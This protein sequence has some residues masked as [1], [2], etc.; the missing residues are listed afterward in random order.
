M[1]SW[2][3]V[4]LNCNGLRSSKEKRLTIFRYLKKQKPHVIFLQE[5]HS[6]PSD[7][8]LWEMEFGK[9]MYLNHC[10]GTQGA[11]TAI[12]C[13]LND[14]SI[15]S[16]QTLYDGRVQVVRVQINHRHVSLINV[17]AP[18]PEYERKHFF[19]KI[20]REVQAK[21]DTELIFGGDFN[22]IQNAALDR[23]GGNTPSK[24]G[25]EGLCKMKKDLDLVDIWRIKNP[26]K[27]DYTWRTKNRQVKSR[28]DYFLISDSLKNDVSK[29]SIIDSLKTDHKAIVIQFK[30]EPECRGPNFWKLN[31]SFL[32]DTRYCS[33][34]QNT[35]NTVWDQ[36]FDI[37]DLRIRWD[38]LKFE[39]QSASIIFTKAKAKERRQE[40]AKAW[41]VLNEIDS[42][43][44][45]GE[46]SDEDLNRY[47]VTKINLEKIE[48]YKAK[49]EYIRSR[50]EFIEK[51]EKSTS[52]FYSQAKLYSK[53]KTLRSL[54]D[55]DGNE[56]SDSDVVLSKIKQFYVD[57]YSSSNPKLKGMEWEQI[58]ATP[59]VGTL[60]DHEKEF[61]DRQI[62][63]D[64]CLI[65]LKQMKPN[66]SPG[67][68]GLGPEFYL[69]FWPI[70]NGKLLQV[71]KYSLE[72]GE[73]SQ[74]QRRAVITLLHKK[75]KDERYIKNWRPISLLNYDYKILTKVLAKRTDGV[76]TKLI[77]EDQSGFIKGRFIGENVRYLSDLIEFAEAEQY[78][79]ILLSLDFFKAYDTI[80]W[81][82]LCECLLKFNFGPAMIKWIKTCYTNIFSTVMNNGFSCGWF[83]I[84]RG[85]RQGCPLSG[86][87][88][89]LCIEIFGCM[90][91][92]NKNIK[93]VKINKVEKKMV[94]FADDTNC[95]VVDW[96]SVEQL[97]LTVKSFSKYSGLNVNIDK[98]ML[99]WMG[100]WRKKAIPRELNVK[101]MTHTIDALGITIGRN[102]DMSTKSNFSDKIDKMTKNFDRWKFR[103]LSLL[104]RI[105]ITKSFG[106]SNLVYSMSV[107]QTPTLIIKKAQAAINGFIWN[108][109]TTRVKHKTLIAPYDCGGL[110]APDVECQHKALRVV[111]VGRLL[112]IRSWGII[113]H[114]YFDKYGGLEFLLKCDYSTKFLHR[115]PIFYR[116]MLNYLDEIALKFD[117]RLII[118]N[119][120]NIIINGES[121][122]WAD[123]KENGVVYI[124]DLQSEDGIFL[125]YEAFRAKFT[126]ETNFVK[127]YSLLCAVRKSQLHNI[128]KVNDNKSIFLVKTFNNSIINLKKAKSRAFYDEY[129]LLC[130]KEP[131][132]VIKWIENVNTTEDEFYR[133][134]PA[135]KRTCGET[136]LL[137]FHYKT[138]HGYLAVGTNLYKWKL[139]ESDKCSHCSDRDT[140]T[141][142]LFSCPT[143]RAWLNEIYA[144]LEYHGIRTGNM[145]VRQFMFGTQSKPLNLILTIVKY[146]I[147]KVRHHN[148]KFNLNSIRYEIYKRLIADKNRL[149]EITFDIKWS[150]Y[151]EII[152]DLKGDFG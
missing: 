128:V 83:Q 151:S 28:L 78:P 40:E 137:D 36:S 86:I 1:Q 45:A 71:Y 9:K 108:N 66:K 123:W 16:H 121:V 37:S 50:A 141:H 34:I 29:V 79:C 7:E 15:H 111:W 146:Y 125:T 10:H 116:E 126:I 56:I 3:I 87:L 106:L 64:E 139:R 47:E 95:T 124:E 101:V 117:S 132:A 131:T 143:T 61:M 142:C 122:F 59:V 112:Q 58:K 110:R 22:T 48:S 88:F 65:A 84:L 134:Y 52:F 44:I 74:S 96:V 150:Q 46:A 68:D 57:L 81:K 33:L 41:E 102:A 136:K 24:V 5:T 26:N 118:W 43:I 140:I 138:L 17:Y 97:F 100:P 25:A 13:T 129:I 92:E 54:V 30:F 31:Q 105:L 39:I 113:A 99:L 93:G 2:K 115:I 32:D 76:L 73:L 60:T 130:S 133:S 80:E 55:E 49:G 8:S 67:C 149:T 94:Q 77:H 4:S 103:N 145:D 120:R 35:I 109:S 75:C 63:S 20:K 51:D 114:F 104:G 91:R 27:R 135:V 6:T 53:K 42:R 62:T 72:R 14:C 19:E 70:L 107:L 147:W 21:L 18:N 148:L 90:V 89:I 127:Y 69:K 11:G 38:L 85:I 152:N 82:F 12:I 23:A 119:N 98:S 144:Y